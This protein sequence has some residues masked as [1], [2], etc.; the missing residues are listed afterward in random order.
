MS[1]HH[2]AVAALFL[3]LL[4]VIVVAD[5]PVQVEPVSNRTIVRQINVTGTVTSPRTAV[6]S[7]AVAGLVAELTIDEG[8][9]VETGQA[10]LQLDA[11]LAQLAL[12]RALAEVRQRETAVADARRRFAEAEKVGTQRGIARTQIESLRA[13]VSNDEAALV[14]SQAAAREQQAIVARHTLKAPFAGVIS[15]RYAELGEWVNPG[16]GLLELV[17][18]DNLRFDFRVGQENFAALSPDI[19]VEITLDAVSERSVSGRVDTIVPVKDPSARTFLVRVLADTTEADNPLR[20]TPGMSARGK[21]NIDTGRSGVAVSRDAILRFPDGRVTV[22]VVDTG[23]DPPVVHERVVRTGF[24]FD[25]IVE[26]TNGLADGDVVVVRGNETLQEGQT[27]SIL[28]GN[29]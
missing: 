13:E 7:T 1:V 27:V 11:E 28:G 23:G 29:P 4:S 18:T 15:E 24:E 21:L 26:I 16:N 8:H 14:A 22:W 19:P 5:V 6:L 10:L 2:R 17:A 25:G 3:M 9:R 20:I 12:E